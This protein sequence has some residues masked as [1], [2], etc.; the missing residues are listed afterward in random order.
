MPPPFFS[1]GE[2]ARRPTAIEPFSG[3]GGM[4]LGFE[5]AGFDIL[6]AVDFDPAGRRVGTKCRSRGQ[7][8]GQ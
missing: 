3:A 1:Q 6:A 4:A 8:G 2:Q 5:Q 7:S